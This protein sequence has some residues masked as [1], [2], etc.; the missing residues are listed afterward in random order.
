MIEI[1]FNKSTMHL[2]KKAERDVKRKENNHL[3]AF[4]VTFSVLCA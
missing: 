3:C 4:V 1:N 2:R